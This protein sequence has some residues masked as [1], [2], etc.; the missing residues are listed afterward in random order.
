MKKLVRLTVIILIAQALVAVARADDVSDFYRGRTIQLIVGY[1]PGGGYDVFSR[2]IARY[3]PK[4]MPGNPSIVVENMPG[5]GSL[6]SVNYLY[7]VAPKD[8]TV[9]ASID[10]SMPLL[11]LLDVN[12]G[13]KFDVRKFTWLGSSSD[14]SDDASI[15]WV[16]KDAK[17]KTVEDARVSGGPPLLLGSTG[18]GGTGNDVTNILRDALHLNIKMISGY[19]DSNAI[20]LAMERGEVEGRVVDYSSIVSTEPQW[21]TPDGP[22][23]AFLQFGRATRNPN[24]PD[25]PTARELAQNENDRLFIELAETPNLVARPFA[26]PPGVPPDRAEALR[27][28]FM[29]THRDPGFLADAKKLGLGISPIDDT[30]ILKAI[31]KITNAPPALLDRL[32]AIYR[33]DQN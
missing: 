24:F 16:R 29:E 23:R 8:G 28:A 33:A 4:Y 25:T 7:S 14:F 31:D 10:R 27:N 17:N 32:R 30:Q 20:N 13:V 22:M 3:M 26:A 18:Q 15:M 11:G 21:L 2:L 1:G 9:F 6:T 12:K 19:P 5:A